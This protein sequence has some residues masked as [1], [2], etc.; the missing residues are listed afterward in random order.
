MTKSSFCY[1]WSTCC[2][3]SK[4]WQ[5]SGL[6]FTP[7][8][9]SSVVAT[10]DLDRLLALCYTDLFVEKKLSLRIWKMMTGNLGDHHLFLLGKND[11]GILNEVTSMS[12]EQSP[13][14]W[15]NCASKVNAYCNEKSI[16]PFH[17]FFKWE[18]LVFSTKSIVK[19][20]HLSLSNLDKKKLLN[21]VGNTSTKL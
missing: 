3:S 4:A 10:D 17:F 6:L 18:T 2:F 8:T 1:K 11:D 12:F 19:C 16:P 13:R 5:L 7:S 21:F 15:E 20:C 14:L 9:T